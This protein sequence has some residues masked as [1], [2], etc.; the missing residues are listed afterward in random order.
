MPMHEA[1]YSKT[2]SIDRLFNIGPGQ[3]TP[4]G[5]KNIMPLHQPASSA[6]P[7]SE[8]Q[9]AVQTSAI[10]GSL[11]HL[12]AHV[13]VGQ[14]AGN[15]QST[16]DMQDSYST[17]LGLSHNATGATST[18]AL[19][20]ENV[21][22]G[23]YSGPTSG[24]TRELKAIEVQ[25]K[26]IVPSVAGDSSVQHSETSHATLAQCIDVQLHER[27]SRK[28]CAELQLGTICAGW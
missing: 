2:T 13:D 1:A 10:N 27:N 28:S 9:P 26:L 7:L 12:Q 15:G 5:S 19:S 20:N 24:L 6:A 21:S 25:N 17:A 22:S 3:R 14:M 16:V 18:R 8:V 11:Q 4:Y 23:A